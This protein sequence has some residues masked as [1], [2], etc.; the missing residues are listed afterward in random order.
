MNDLFVVFWWFGPIGLGVFFAGA[1][2]LLWGLSKYR[3][4]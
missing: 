2:I 1:G 4:K 3:K